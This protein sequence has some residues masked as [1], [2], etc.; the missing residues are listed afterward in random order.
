MTR[1]A[2]SYLFAPG[3]QP[4]KIEKAA[5]SGADAVILDLEDSV[6]PAGKD[7][8]RAGVAASLAAGASCALWVRI[9]SL[10]SG[11]A[12]AD[13][14]A[15][16][17]PGLAGLMLPKCEGPTD[18]VRLSH[19]LDALEARAGLAPGSVRIMAVATET[20]GA[21]FTLGQYEGAGP[22]LMGLTWGAEDLA[23]AIGAATNRAP[24]G[25]LA[26]T[27]RMAR[28]LC[29]LG[30]HAAGLTAIETASMEF[31]DEAAIAATAH[32]ARREG[33]GAMLAIHPAQIGPIHAA[34]TPTAEEIDSARAVIAAFAA[35]PGAGTVGLN[36]KMLDIP[37]LT[38]A[39]KLLAL[40]GI[41]E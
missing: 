5:T 27:Y 4:R 23:A 15:V 20:P 7:A 6:V 9:N 3:D 16:V 33:F 8:A 21:V 41:A 13:L 11:L 35:A 40:A 10:A 2:R 31:R 38:Q 30:A 26:L 17:A 24:D 37:H 39:R 22:R 28:S 29:L 1:P 25:T 14:A 12:L 36:G 18:I 19:Y 34:F 32:A